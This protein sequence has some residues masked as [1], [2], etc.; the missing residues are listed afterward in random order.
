MS[1][2][3][4]LSEENFIKRTKTITSFK[5]FM[6]RVRKNL[7]V[8]L[9]G[10]FLHT[11]AFLIRSLLIRPLRNIL[12]TILCIPVALKLGK[13]KHERFK[14]KGKYLQCSC[15]QWYVSFVNHNSTSVMF[16]ATNIHASMYGVIFPPLLVFK[17][18]NRPKADEKSKLVTFSQD[19]DVLF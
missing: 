5:D 15:L 12:V 9:L 14:N 6:S 4:I 11:N 18:L 2:C 7:L 16:S 17:K 1:K 13:S 10:W 8:M 19:L 3:Y